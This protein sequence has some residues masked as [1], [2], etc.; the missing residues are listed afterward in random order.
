MSYR[1]TAEVF[2]DEYAANRVLSLLEPPI[3]PE[4]IKLDQRSIIRRHCVKADVRRDASE[5]LHTITFLD[6]SAAILICG[7][8]Q[9]ERWEVVR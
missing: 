5:R 2:C 1:T 3:D 9:S 7:E 4:L 8:G 6:G